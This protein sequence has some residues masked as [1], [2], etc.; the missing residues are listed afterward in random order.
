MKKIISV[1]ALAT[2]FV[3]PIACLADAAS[4]PENLD[5]WDALETVVTY[6]FGLLIILA[7]MFLVI[8]GILFITAQGDLEKVK[9]ARDFVLWAL[10]GVIVG[11]LAYALVNF[12]QNMVG[13]T[14]VT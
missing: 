6:L 10:V 2:L 9:K 11:V 13:A 14:P 7:V 12:V 3:L 4:P 1:L 5:L 8:A